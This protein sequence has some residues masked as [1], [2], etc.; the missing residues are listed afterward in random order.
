MASTLGQTKP[1]QVGLNGVRFEEITLRPAQTA[2][3]SEMLEQITALQ[4]A[5]DEDDFRALTDDAAARTR[6]FLESAAVSLNAVPLGTVAADGD[7]GL[8]I[9]WIRLDRE[10]RL[11]VS[12]SA[13]GR[14]YLYYEQSESYGADYAPS[15]GELSR[16]LRWLEAPAA[17]VS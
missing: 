11:V 17:E 8:R 14:S 4:G 9:E 3:L 12:A 10:L 6:A 15:A 7:G 16:R 5:A 1:K 13:S 2:G